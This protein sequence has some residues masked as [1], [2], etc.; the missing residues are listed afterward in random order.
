MI[1]VSDTSPLTALLT[2]GED[3]LL[4][5]LFNEAVIPV[6][7]QNEL[8]RKHALNKNRAPLR[9]FLTK[10]QVLDNSFYCEKRSHHAGQ[11]KTQNPVGPEI[12]RHP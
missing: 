12:R 11:T 7:V 9:A 3:R 4:T 10:V 1:V 5:N 8:L 6:A 2:V